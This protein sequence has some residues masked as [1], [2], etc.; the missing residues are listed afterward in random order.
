MKFCKIL[1]IGVA[2]LAAVSCS[3]P[4]DIVYFQDMKAGETELAVTEPVEIKVRAKDKLSIIVSTQDEKLSELFNLS[5]RNQQTSQTGVKMGY[6]VDTDGYINF[7]VL[8]KL[9]LEGMTREQIAEFITNELKT[10]ELV[11]DPVVIVEFMNLSVS[12]LGEVSSPGRYDIDRDN[13]TVLNAISAAGD[14]SINGRRVN[15]KVLREE[16]GKQKVYEMDLCDASTIYSSPAY[17]LQQDDVVYVEPNANKARQS[18]VNGN[19]LLTPAF[20]MSAVSFLM[21]IVVLI[22]K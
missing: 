8:G 3:T 2:L 19:T 5:T 18:T 17:Y 15:V 10:R 20:W 16:N 6:T 21:S 4:K 9:K 12:V 14:L 13:Y 1:M 22:A 11:K 7:P